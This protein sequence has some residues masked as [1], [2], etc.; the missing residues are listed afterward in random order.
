M[1]WKDLNLMSVREEFVVKALEPGANLSALCRE[2]GVSRKTGYKWLERYRE[3]GLRG[4]EDLSRCPR[5]SPL[6]VSGE[7]VAEV[8]LLRREHPEY[9]PKKLA[10]MVERRFG[11]EAPSVRTVARILERT[12]MVQRTR[13]RRHEPPRIE[14]LRLAPGAP[15]ELWTVD[16][17]GWWLSQN[18]E[19][20][21]PLTVRDA[22]SRFVLAIDVMQSTTQLA[23][24]E[25]F[26]TVFGRYGLPQRILVDNGVPWISATSKVGL[27]QLSAWWLSLGI[28]VLRTRPGTPSDNG[29][30]ERMHRDMAAELE[31]Y[32]SMTRAKQQAACD[33]WRHAFNHVR[34]HE[35]L[36]MKTPGEVYERSRVHYDGQPTVQVY[37]DGMLVRRVSSCGQVRHR[38]TYVFVSA[39]LATYDVA[40]EPLEDRRYVVWFC[41]HRVGL[42]DFSTAP[43]TLDASVW[44]HGV[45]DPCYVGSDVG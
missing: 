17:K 20:C 28:D 38:K 29:G 31:R 24:R 1:P 11:E 7:V 33:R 45:I 13:R 2:Y 44:N 8:V 14:P 19:R 23:V 21:E 25:R 16:F 37:P 32:A 4:L 9:G 40:L 12:G 39:A 15:N 41:H 22:H 27:T 5:G 10:V 42:A 36:G 6:A 35:A 26:E 34:P 30:H 3:E 43:A 18:G